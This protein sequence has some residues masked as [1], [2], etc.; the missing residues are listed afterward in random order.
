MMPRIESAGRRPVER[1]LSVVIHF[2]WLKT[3]VLRKQHGGTD[4]NRDARLLLF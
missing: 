1:N 3:A 2:N 4:G